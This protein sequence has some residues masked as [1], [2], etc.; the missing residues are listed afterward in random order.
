M[1]TF[2]VEID[3]TKAGYVRTITGPELPSKK[4][5][6][7][8]EEAA[9]AFARGVLQT[10]YE[11]WEMGP[12]DRKVYIFIPAHSVIDVRLTELVA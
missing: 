8:T 5:E 7:S 9:F 6:L 2:R 12:Y 11:T 10:G 4:G 1:K 3:T